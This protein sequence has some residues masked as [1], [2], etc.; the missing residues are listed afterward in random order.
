MKSHL[1]TMLAVLTLNITASAY[2]PPKTPVTFVL[3]SNKLNTTKTKIWNKDAAVMDAYK[4]LL[5]DAGKALKEGPFSVMEKKQVPPSGD[6]HD[7]MSL[8]PYHWPDPSKPDGLPYI[9]KDGQTNPEVKDFSDKEYM[10]RMCEAAYTLSLAYFFSGDEQYAEHAAKLLKVWFLNENTKMNP[11]LN[12]AQ[13]MKGSNDGRGAGIIDSRHFIKIVDAI[14]L[15]KGSKYW[16]EQ[17][18]NG[19]KQWFSS[20]LNWMHASKNGQHE[21]KTLNN[22]GTYFDAIRLSL[23]L[24]V[25]STDLA[26]RIVL[27]VQSRLDNQMDEEGKF[28]KEMART[29]ALH[30]STFNL[31]AFF[32]IA[33]MAERVN[34]DLWNYTSP[35]GKSLKNGFNFLYPYITKKKDWT[36]SQIK[37]FDYADGY[38]VL[39]Q[40]ADKFKCKS[41][42]QD[43]QNLA[44]EKAL[45]LRHNL[46]Y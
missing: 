38:P 37:D 41:C 18:Q 26:N 21:I 14:G 45:R 30:Y 46:L 36:G 33:S 8:A 12:F 39:L 29:I 15:L 6:K 10:P 22:H 3:N 25:D 43:V 31:N 24:F 23:A 42:R 34:I 11:N 19:M 44:G 27:N 35:S 16:K 40:A 20:F 7:F 2:T 32:M 17:D 13:A 28:P 1:I 4:Q 5:K 9:R